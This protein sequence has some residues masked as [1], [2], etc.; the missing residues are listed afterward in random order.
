MIRMNEPVISPRN[1]FFLVKK[2]RVRRLYHVLNT[3]EHL[4]QH[5]QQHQVLL[6]HCHSH[7]NSRCNQMIYVCISA[8]SGTRVPAA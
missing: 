4:P 3:S 6:Y 8:H 5:E 7:P 1:E 2:Y